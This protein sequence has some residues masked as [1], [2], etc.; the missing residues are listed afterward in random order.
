MRVDHP[1]AYQPGFMLTVLVPVVVPTQF[2]KDLTDMSINGTWIASL[3][4][5][6]MLQEKAESIK[7][8]QWG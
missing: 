7:I 2:F 3:R 4:L 8:H 1:R 5:C 6:K